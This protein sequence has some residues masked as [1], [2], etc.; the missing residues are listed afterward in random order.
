MSAKKLLSVAVE[1]ERKII[2]QLAEILL[3]P[4]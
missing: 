3:M 1:V 2:S 4:L